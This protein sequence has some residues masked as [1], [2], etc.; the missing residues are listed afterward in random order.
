MTSILDRLL[1]K[2]AQAQP[3]QAHEGCCGGH[4]K[5]GH[6]AARESAD[7][8]AGGCCGDNGHG[9]TAPAAAPDTPAERAHSLP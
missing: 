1:G 2:P 6:Q 4:G 7:H 3:T 8:A 9:D 5:G